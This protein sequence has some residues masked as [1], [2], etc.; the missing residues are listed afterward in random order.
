MVMAK[1]VCDKDA[2]AMGVRPWKQC[3]DRRTDHA[4]LHIEREIS[5]RAA[6][7]Q[8]HDPPPSLARA[9]AYRYK[10]TR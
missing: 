3:T 8:G 6:A 10:P 2:V 4:D 9:L 7:S 5:M 1:F